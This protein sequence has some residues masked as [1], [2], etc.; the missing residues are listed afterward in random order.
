MTLILIMIQLQEWWE[1]IIRTL[2]LKKKNLMR[3]IIF[4]NHEINEASRD[5][6]TNGKELKEEMK[7]KKKGEFPIL[8]HT[9][10]ANIYRRRLFS[11]ICLYIFFLFW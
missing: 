10:L 3:G 5:R 1:V 2:W 7:R 9:N 6:A 11:L 4:N 8:Q